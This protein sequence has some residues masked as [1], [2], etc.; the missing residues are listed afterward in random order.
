MTD[1]EQLFRNLLMSY[2]IEDDEVLE[3]TPRRYIAMLDELL[4]YNDR[5]WEFTTFDSKVNSMVIVSDIS[6][7]SL[8]EHH[9]LPFIG[10][11]HVAYIPQGK[12]AGL[13]KIARA[14]Q[15]M[16]RGLWT[17][18]DLTDDIADHLIDKLD[19][20]GVAVIMQAEHTCMTIRGIKAHGAKTTTSAMRGAFLENDNLARTE[21]MGLIR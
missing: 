8:C 21:F 16:C 4:G 6:F 2:G 19:P 15:T 10:K 3:N 5:A 17:Q 20:R 14:V 11:A 1:D 9:V 13:S 12:V 7:H 18:E